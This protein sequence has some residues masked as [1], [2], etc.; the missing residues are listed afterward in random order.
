[1]PAEQVLPVDDLGAGPAELEVG[2]ADL[3]LGLGARDGGGAGDRGGRARAGQL[4]QLATAEL[5]G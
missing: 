3:P 5:G 2:Q 1:V 4:E